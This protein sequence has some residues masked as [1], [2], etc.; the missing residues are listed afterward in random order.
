MPANL[1]YLFFLPIAGK[2]WSGIQVFVFYSLRPDKQGKG[3]DN[4]KRKR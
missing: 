2:N 1:L 4:G 3:G